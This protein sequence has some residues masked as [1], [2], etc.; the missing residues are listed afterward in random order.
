MASASIA[1]VM[2][3]TPATVNISRERERAA[4]KAD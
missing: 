2:G 4:L 3:I 1:A